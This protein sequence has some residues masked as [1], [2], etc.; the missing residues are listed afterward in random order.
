MSPLDPVPT[1]DH[2]GVDPDKPL[3]IVDV[4]EVLALFF[5]GFGQFVERSGYEMRVDRF[6]L[7]QNIYRR[8]ESEHLEIEHGQT[9]LG[10]FFRIAAEEI[11]PAPGAAHGLRRLAHAGASV[12]IL[13]NSP[14]HGRAPR[15]RW[16]A[17]HGMDYPLIMNEGLKGPVI[18][19]LA[20]QTSGPV[21][22]VDDLLSQLDS[23]VEAAPRVHTFQLV[24]DLRLRPI[25]P[26]NPERHRRID[27]WPQLC[28]E[29]A[30]VLGLDER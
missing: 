5:H 16:L 30:Q 15:V 25:A 6:A 10:E 29:L 13:T 24:A 1:T 14:N 2:P 20:R 28:D 4:D 27:H 19:E 22:F 23:A 21:A 9:L 11:E 17:R 12:V 3:L 7:F 26:T 18:A 8:G